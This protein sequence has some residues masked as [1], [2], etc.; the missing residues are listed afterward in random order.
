MNF[1][2]NQ[3]L[4]SLT[5]LYCFLFVF[6]KPPLIFII[7]LILLLIHSLKYL[8]GTLCK[9]PL[10]FSLWAFLSAVV[11][12][13]ANSSS[14]GLSGY[15]LCLLNSGSLWDFIPLCTAVWKLWEAA[16][17]RGVTSSLMDHCPLLPDVQFLE[18]YF[19]YFCLVFFVF[20]KSVSGRRLDL[21]PY[22]FIL[23]YPLLLSFLNL[24]LS[25]L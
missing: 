22:Y 25:K 11:L 1:S 17:I 10:D 4:V 21:V 20:K 19:T 2:E 23:A 3:L 18:N 24:V 8:R 6:L 9:N 15:L 13:S 16:A 14:L 7:Y 12:C 5:F